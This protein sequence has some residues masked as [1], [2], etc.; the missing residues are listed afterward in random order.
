MSSKWGGDLPGY[1]KF[2]TGLKYKDVYEML[3]TSKKHR[4]RRRKTVL[5]FWHELKLQLYHQAV[6]LGYD[7][8]EA[9]E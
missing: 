8:E 5:G 7:E 4:Y 1:K 3:G 2:R 9:R 6:N